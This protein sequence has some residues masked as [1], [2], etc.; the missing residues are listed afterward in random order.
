MSYAFKKVNS[1]FDNNK[2]NQQSQNQSNIV[3]TNSHSPSSTSQPNQNSHQSDFRNFNKI[4]EANKDQGSQ[5]QTGLDKN[6]A[7]QN[8]GMQQSSQEYKGGLQNVANQYQYDPNS[9]KD[10]AGNFSKLQSILNPTQQ[11]TQIKNVQSG[12][13]DY[14]PNTQ[15]VAQASTVGGLSS[16]LQNQY[17]TTQGQSRLDALL[18]RNSGQAGQ[19]IRNNLQ[20]LGQ[21]RQGQ[22]ENLAQE[23]AMRNKF[24]DQSNTNAAQARTDLGSQAAEYEKLAK[25]QMDADL[26]A[27]QGADG[28]GGL[29]GDA[30]KELQDLLTA[31]N[32][33]NPEEMEQV[34][35]ALYN[36]MKETDPY[37]GN[38]GSAS[39][40]NNQYLT[41]SMREY[42]DKNK[43]NP[44]EELGIGGLDT[45]YDMRNYFVDRMMN[46]INRDY[47]G[48]D[49][50]VLGNYIEKP[51][52]YTQEQ[53]L[54]PQFNQ[55]AQ[56]L[57]QQQKDLSTPKN[58]NLVT[59][60][61]DKLNNDLLA[62]RG[63]YVTKL[64]NDIQSGR[65]AK[66]AEEDALYDLLNKY[67]SS[68][69]GKFH[70]I[71]TGGMPQ[72]LPSAYSKSKGFIED[73][74]DVLGF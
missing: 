9:V 21:F 27:Y 25:A 63:D 71:V 61:K 2:N 3:D 49:P 38:A 29:Y 56:L 67:G 28:K 15:A 62:S 16:L 32:Q 66:I 24:I 17:N 54:N 69:L 19:S 36:R 72:F 41:N 1:L 23:E 42:I 37:Y 26:L 14:K 12:T 30:Q 59:T 40:Y 64:L 20:D 34:R 11:Q 43:M 65:S 53:Y 73:I 45:V 35:K 55:I 60:Q 48:L 18:S 68:N 50:S 33:F 46:G 7:E 13:G 6:I 22:Q 31:G 10:A 8:Q 70:G 44:V 52:Q 47:K 39:R 51:D 4:Y 58:D 57:G 5:V 74:G